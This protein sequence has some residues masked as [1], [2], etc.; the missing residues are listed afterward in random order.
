MGLLS[1]YDANDGTVKYERER[2]PQGRSFTASPWAADGRVF[3]LNE[4]GVT[5]VFQA[6]DRFE[7][8][9]TNALAEDDLC[10]ATP[11]VAGNRLL[12]RTA[13][14]LYCIGGA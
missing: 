13:A 14:R 5:F 8:L 6:G 10:L 4:D 3:C 12:V 11:A 2:I 1:C 9:H 7:L